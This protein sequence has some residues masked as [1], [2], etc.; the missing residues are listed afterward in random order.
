MRFSKRTPESAQEDITV[1][2]VVVNVIEQ[3]VERNISSENVMYKKLETQEHW[4]WEVRLKN[5]T[6]IT[7]AMTFYDIIIVLVF[8]CFTTTSEII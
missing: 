2:T 3:T 5:Q 8:H 1:S 6:E 4:R 7:L